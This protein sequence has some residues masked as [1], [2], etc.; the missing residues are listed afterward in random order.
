LRNCAKIITLFI[1]FSFILC[2]FISPPLKASAEEENYYVVEADETII[3]DTKGTENVSDDD[4]FIIP[5]TYYLLH[6]GEQLTS[7]NYYYVVYN[8]IHG[9]VLK[10]DVSELVTADVETPYYS[11]TLTISDTKEFI[12]IYA[13]PSQMSDM[14]YTFNKFNNPSL[15]YFGYMVDPDDDTKIWYYI[16]YNNGTADQMGYVLASFTDKAELYSQIPNHPDYNENT[17]PSPSPSSPAVNNPEEPTNN[18]LRVILILGISVPAVI[19][20][21]LLFKPGKRSRSYRR[22]PVRDR[23]YYDDYD[24]YEEDYYY[25]DYRDSRRDYRRRR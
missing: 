15:E 21:F 5:K 19:V 6:D 16:K 13:E 11:E 4:E 9:K 22:P 23:D 3:I 18:L 20:V 25:D 14:N 12:I 7:N 24:D 17:S 2:F 1:L 10:S 8:G